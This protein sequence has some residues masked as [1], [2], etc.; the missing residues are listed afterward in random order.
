M[1][2]L[3]IAIPFP[4]CATRR[5]LVT[6]DSGELGSEVAEQLARIAGDTSMDGDVVLVTRIGALR[7]FERVSR[8][9][10]KY[11]QE[12][13]THGGVVRGV[14]EFDFSIRVDLI[15]L[16]PRAATMTD[17]QIVRWLDLLNRLALRSAREIRRKLRSRNS[18]GL[19]PEGWVPPI[20]PMFEPEDDEIIS[21]SWSLFSA[22][23]VEDWH[24][25][26]LLWTRTTLVSLAQRVGYALVRQWDL[27]LPAQFNGAPN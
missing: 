13:M 6:P 10:P 18:E 23:D 11:I 4:Y 20:E 2:E 1:T 16:E 12:A 14:F 5:V 27:E 19:H 9:D 7:I 21:G 3:Q 15:A 25:G 24:A 26:L 8:A 17:E 22:E